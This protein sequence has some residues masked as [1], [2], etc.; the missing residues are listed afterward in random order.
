MRLRAVNLFRSYP[1]VPGEAAQSCAQK[2]FFRGL[3]ELMWSAKLNARLLELV[4]SKAAIYDSYISEMEQM[5]CGSE[6]SILPSTAIRWARAPF[7]YFRPAIT[8][9]I[10][11]IRHAHW[12]RRNSNIRGAVAREQAHL[13]RALLEREAVVHRQ[14]LGIHPVPSAWDSSVDAIREV[15][16]QS[17]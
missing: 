10:R 14:E 15:Y 5:P 6:A 11:S 3:P 16:S 13:A 12:I 1:V 2:F 4:R 7:V 8:V 17:K 9:F